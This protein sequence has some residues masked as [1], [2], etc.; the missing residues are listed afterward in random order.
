MGSYAAL[1][2][3]PDGPAPDP[4][5]LAPLPPL[6]PADAASQLLGGAL[7]GMQPT[8]VPAPVTQPAPVPQ[9]FTA[10]RGPT[11]LDAL[12]GRVSAAPAV[13][14]PVAPGQPL[15]LAS[16][17]PGTQLVRVP[18]ADGALTQVITQAPGGAASEGPSASDA[19]LN[20]EE[21]RRQAAEQGKALEALGRT[22]EQAF[23]TESRAIDNAALLNQKQSQAELAARQ[24]AQ[25]A[26][27][28]LD[29]EHA[30]KQTFFDAE[31]EKASAAVG[32]AID[33]AN[34]TPFDENHY[35][36][37]LGAGGTALTL[38][39]L[40]FGGFATGF[41]RGPNVGLQML[42]AAI[43]RDIDAQ[44]FAYQ[45]KRQ[46]VADKQTAY[47]RLREAGFDE[48]QAYQ[49][50]TLVATAKLN[51]A[52]NVMLAQYGDGRADAQRQM[53]QAA[54]GQRAAAA[55][56]GL[57]Q[58][59]NAL[60]AQKWGQGI[61]L[62]QVEAL[63]NKGNGMAGYAPFLNKQAELSQLTVPGLKGHA[64]SPE[65]HSK[66]V[67]I[68]QSFQTLVPMIDRMSQMRKKE[69]RSF[70]DPEQTARGQAL[71]TDISVEAKNLFDLGAL[72]NSDMNLIKSIIPQ[73]PS[74][75]FTFDSTVQGKL[76]EFRHNIEQKRRQKLGALGF[77][78]DGTDSTQPVPGEVPLR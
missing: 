2:P 72:S 36:H 18:G 48:T 15:Q 8:V 16:S 50:A 43:D 65:E 32:K 76:K 13:R 70:L 39:S 53:L 69:G 78:P 66:A 54:L 19:L 51:T 11:A 27:A 37:S 77:S 47:A 20:P 44:K 71:A 61:A 5:T 60:A 74:A 58:T 45:K 24:D 62:A 64:K 9:P 6:A 4:S 7:G 22:Q 29:A 17:M 38:L 31:R 41:T 75:I 3:V 57:L 59:T 49:G 46:T 30:K 34:A 40:A 42:D 35:M 26:Q 63:G 10:D 21:L 23:A 12:L 67:A 14:A 55:Q 1:P 28:V 33:E 52:L 25:R 73:D 68:E 56:G